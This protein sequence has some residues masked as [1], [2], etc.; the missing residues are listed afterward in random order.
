MRGLSISAPSN[1]RTTLKM[2]PKNSPLKLITSFEERKDPIPR[3]ATTSPPAVG[4]NRFFSGG[5]PRSA[6]ATPIAMSA[7]TPIDPFWQ[8]DMFPSSARTIT[9]GP[10]KLAPV[11]ESSPADATPKADHIDRLPLPPPMPEERDMN[12]SSPIKAR[13]SSGFAES[14]PVTLGDHSRNN[15]PAPPVSRIPSPPQSQPLPGPPSSVFHQHVRKMSAARKPAGLNIQW[16][17]IDS[18]IHEGTQPVSG[19][20][21]RGHQRKG[22]RTTPPPVGLVLPAKK[23][24][25]SIDNF[26]ELL[27]NSQKRLDSQRAMPRATPRL[28]GESPEPRGRRPPAIDV[29]ATTDVMIAEMR[30]RHEARARPALHRSPSSPLPMSDQAK[31]YREDERD[32]HASEEPEPAPEPLEDRYFGD[33]RGRARSASRGRSPPRSKEAQNYR[34]ESDDEDYE[35]ER[36]YTTSRGR[37]RSKTLEEKPPGGLM[38]SPSSPL[39]MSPQAKLYQQMS[40]EADNDDDDERHRQRRPGRLARTDSRTRG[41]QLPR[42]LLA[43]VAP[44]GIRRSRSERTLRQWSDQLEQAAAAEMRHHS[45]APSLS[46]NRSMSRGLPSNPR[47]WRA[48]LQAESRNGSRANSPAPPARD[49]S[50]AMAP[51]PPP[52][53]QRSGTPGRRAM[54]PLARGNDGR[55]ASP[56][57]RAMS[58]MSRTMS[59]AIRERSLSRPGARKMS[60]ADAIPALPTP[61]LSGVRRGTEPIIPTPRSANYYYPAATPNLDSYESLPNSPQINIPAVPALPALTPP[62]S[63]SGSGTGFFSHHGHQRSQSDQA[64]QEFAPLIRKLPPQP[65]PD[66]PPPLPVDLPVHPRL[67]MNLDPAQPGRRTVRRVQRSD[68]LRE[69]EQSILV[70]IDA[71]ET[72]A[73]E[74]GPPIEIAVPPRR[75]S[76]AGGYRMA[77]SPPMMGLDQAIGSMNQI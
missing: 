26:L 69:D 46:R 50:P 64:S 16:P 7:L 72:R 67:Q 18:V 44:G 42:H 32:N 76:V 41:P 58:P 11:T 65:P 52:P 28:R 27:E 40:A 74:S 53:P 71:E 24:P 1:P 35:D 22:S 9:P 33:G 60:E 47:A 10:Q 14:K 13:N 3:S 15:S 38:R 25:G 36:Y 68:E 6:T 43:A 75:P 45:P 30:G 21:P 54:S 29:A 4:V 12:I 49:R 48:E 66:S 63:G 73:W 62:T 19:S 5:G 39:P 20:P 17:P 77:P 34:E 55:N 59:P 37:G 61:P 57:R 2:T 56:G 31:L 70:G 23:S 51:A 8:N